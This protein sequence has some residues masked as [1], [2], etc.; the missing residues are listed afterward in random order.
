M[1]ISNNYVVILAGG[2]GSRFWPYSRQKFPKQF[3]DILHV[4]KTLLQLT[5]DRFE[6]ICPKEN[7]Y[8]VTNEAYKSLVIDQLPYLSENQV[9]LEPIGK[10]TAACVCYAANKIIQQ[11]TA[12]NLLI[13]PSDHIIFREDE[14]KTK[15]TFV[16]NKLNENPG[17]LVTFGV[18]PSRPD[19]GYGYIQIGTDESSDLREVKS[20]KEKP[21]LETAIKFL[22]SGDYVWNAGVFAWKASTIIDCFKKFLPDMQQLFTSNAYYSSAEKELIYK[23]YHECE[24]ISIDY[25]ILEKASNINTMIGDFGWSDLGTWK[26]LYESSD[27]DENDNVLD[28]NILAYKTTDCIIKTPA[29]KLVVTYGLEGFIVAEFEGAL[30]ICKKEDEQKVKDIVGDLKTN[31]YNEYL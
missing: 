2:V 31:N 28:G 24:S 11:N 6:G 3:H 21:V 14:F 12:A 30:M 19:T 22:Q 27:K 16:M 25:G 10:N 1:D 4:G 15:V 17:L 26:S 18:K 9:L 20:F 7:I 13:A 8:I 23:A 29:N 5:A